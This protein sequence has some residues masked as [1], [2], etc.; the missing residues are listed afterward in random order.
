MPLL[1]LKSVHI[2]FVVTWFA[3]LFYL[4][5]LFVYHREAEDKSETEKNILQAQFTIMERRLWYGI[6]VPSMWGTLLSGLS[7]VTFYRYFWDTWLFV[8]LCLVAGL[9]GYHVLCGQMRIKL[10]NH[11]FKLSPL[12]LRLWNEG[13]TLFLVS[14]VF[15]VVLKNILSLF[16]GLLALFGFAMILYAGIKI[17]GK[18]KE[19][20]GRQ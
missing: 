15:L 10:L 14:I 16:W 12:A 18:I 11:E 13:A 19:T 7:I 17:Y 20:K 6:T 4:V 5:R 9:L 1:Y 8:K 2:I 3:G